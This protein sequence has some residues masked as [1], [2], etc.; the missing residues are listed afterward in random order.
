MAQKLSILWYGAVAIQVAE[1]D[2]LVSDTGARQLGRQPG[3]QSFAVRP[4]RQALILG[5]G[6]NVGQPTATE[7]FKRGGVRL[8]AMV[9]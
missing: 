5:E 4:E 3:L 9:T 7:L 6:Q 2:R 8:E 1:A